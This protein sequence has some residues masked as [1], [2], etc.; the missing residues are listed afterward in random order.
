MSGYDQIAPWLAT[1]Y[2]IGKQSADA[3]TVNA[4]A[5][6]IR[7]VAGAKVDNATAAE[8]APNAEVQRAY[9]GAQTG[10]VR[11][12]T[13]QK[14]NL[15]PISEWQGR[16]ADPAAWGML[17]LRPPGTG[18]AAPGTPG[19]VGSGMTGMSSNQ[20]SIL[21]GVP[22]PTLS[23]TPTLDQRQ[24]VGHYSKGTAKVP[25][26][27][28][29][30]VD[31]VPAKLAPGEAVLNKGAA[32]MFGRENIANLNAH[33]AAAMGMPP[34]KGKKGGGPQGFANGTE[35]V[36]PVG[37]TA[38]KTK[39]KEAAAMPSGQGLIKALAQ[40]GVSALGLV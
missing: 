17:G 36:Q 18:M 25:G 2:A 39:V 21:D 16:M 6:M 30:K 15:L 9:T 20:R 31:T 3:A 8:I 34:A 4:N 11:V 10:D 32:E 38:G 35:D 1:K 29:G 13:Q 22:D 26:K 28:S 7:S 33:G 14:T 40:H 24:P 23:L 27:G 12:G 37:K 19:M 5:G